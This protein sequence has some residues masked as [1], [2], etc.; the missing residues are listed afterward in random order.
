[1]SKKSKFAEKC[2]DFIGLCCL[3]LIL[4]TYILYPLFK[5]RLKKQQENEAR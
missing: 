5:K 1:M 2:G 3:W 4:S